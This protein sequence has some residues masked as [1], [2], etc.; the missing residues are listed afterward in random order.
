VRKLGIVTESFRWHIGEWVIEYREWYIWRAR[1]VSLISGVNQFAD[2]WRGCSRY[3]EARMHF[4]SRTGPVAPKHP[5]THRIHVA[6]CTQEH[7]I[8]QTIGYAQARQCDSMPK[9]K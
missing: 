6:R 1:G 5:N 2:L 3:V 9:P 8:S 4:A 7:E